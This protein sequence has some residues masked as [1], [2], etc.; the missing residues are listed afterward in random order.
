[1]YCS[2]SPHSHVRS[3]TTSIIQVN[4]KIGL[5]KGVPSGLA[6]AER[7]LTGVEGFGLTPFTTSDVVR[8]PMAARIPKARDGA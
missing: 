1:M 5:P 2:W 7:I 8:Y 4:C 6:E 3:L